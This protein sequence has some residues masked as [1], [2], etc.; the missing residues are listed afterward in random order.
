MMAEEKSKL[1][2]RLNFKSYIHSMGRFI[3]ILKTTKKY[4]PLS[5]AG[6]FCKLEEQVYNP[7]M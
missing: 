4:H 7:T 6:F 5:M 3:N 1:S 2:Y